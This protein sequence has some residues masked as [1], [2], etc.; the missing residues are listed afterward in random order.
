MTGDSVEWGLLYWAW[1][2]WNPLGVTGT[3]A[4][5]R[6]ELDAR[7]RAGG[8]AERLAVAHRIVPTWHIDATYGPSETV[9]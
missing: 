4:E 7:R 2:S 1:G 9:A 5:V 3:E 6:R 8:L